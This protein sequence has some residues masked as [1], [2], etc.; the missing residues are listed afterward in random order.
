MEID[1]TYGKVFPNKLKE[2]RL[3]KIYLCKIARRAGCLNSM[4]FSAS[5]ISEVHVYHH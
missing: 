2:M 4:D 5:E 1:R 3:L